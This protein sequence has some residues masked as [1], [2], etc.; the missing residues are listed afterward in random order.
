MIILV[1]MWLCIIY[2]IIKFIIGLGQ[3]TAIITFS[4]IIFFFF[5]LV[6]SDIGNIGLGMIVGLVIAV[7]G[8]ACIFEGEKRCAEEKQTKKEIYHQNVYD[9]D[10]GFND[11]NR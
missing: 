3:K 10:L 4:V 1:G 9:D 11:F 6:G 8:V 7:F 5:T 2:C